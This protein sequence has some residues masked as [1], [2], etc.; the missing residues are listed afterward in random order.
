MIS[1][2]HCSVDKENESYVVFWDL[3]SGGCVGS[4][5][6]SHTDDIT[7]VK[8]HP[9][10]DNILATGKVWTVRKQENTNGTSFSSRYWRR[11]TVISSVR[12]SP[13]ELRAVLFASLGQ[14]LS[15]HSFVL[16]SQALRMDSCAFTIST[17]R[18]RTMDCFPL[19]TPS[20][21]SIVS[22]GEWKRCRFCVSWFGKKSKRRSPFGLFESCRVFWISLFLMKR[23]GKLV[24][25]WGQMVLRMKLI[26]KKDLILLFQMTPSRILCDR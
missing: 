4:Y 11:P 2:L 16:S 18:P 19:W 25:F 10:K 1:L 26:A 17:P 7:Q 13:S 24:S 12:M 20:R 9:T 15:M 6:E 14:H 23:L 22:D 8:F 3:R 5:S 21:P